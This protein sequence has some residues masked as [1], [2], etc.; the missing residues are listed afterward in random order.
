M[1]GRCSECDTTEVGCSAVNSPSG[2]LTEYAAYPAL[3][4]FL[5]LTMPFVNQLNGQRNRCF[6]WLACGAAADD[7]EACLIGR[8]LG[9]STLYIALPRCFV[10]SACAILRRVQ[11]K[12]RAP[13][14]AVPH[15][16]QK[17]IFSSDGT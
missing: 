13:V 16:A 12:E 7:M 11:R 4:P 14:L 1:Y 17:H 2:L 5:Q 9:Y 6:L 10:L 8:N 15:L 3:L